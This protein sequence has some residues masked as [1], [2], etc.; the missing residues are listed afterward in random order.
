MKQLANSIENKM[1][2]SPKVVKEVNEYNDF[3]LLPKNG[4]DNPVI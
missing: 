1:Y 3:G 4:I 2:N